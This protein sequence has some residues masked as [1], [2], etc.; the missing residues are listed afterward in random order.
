MKTKQKKRYTDTFMVRMSSIATI[1]LAI[2]VILMITLSITGLREL[3]RTMTFDKFESIAVLI[4]NSSQ[5]AIDG[6]MKA[7][8]EEQD[9]TL[10]F[11]RD[12]KYVYSTD[13]SL[14]GIESEV[15]KGDE[16]LIIHDIDGV[17]YL[18]ATFDM[19]DGT[20]LLISED[21]NHYLNLLSPYQKNLFCTGVIML[22]AFTASVAV[23]SVKISKALIKVEQAVN[24][25][26]SGKLNNEYDAKLLE[27]KDEIGDIYRN[28]KIMDDM[29]VDIV[30]KMQSTINDLKESASVIKLSVETCI[31]NTNGIASA[32]EEVAQGA[33][34]QANEC[35]N[36][37]NAT[38]EINAF[39]ENVVDESNGLKGVSANMSALKD[40]SLNSLNRLVAQNEENTASIQGIAE[41]IEQTNVSIENVVEIIQKIE[42]ISSQTNL[43]SLNASIEAARAGEAGRGFAVVAGEIKALSEQTS[44]LTK[45]IADNITTLNENSAASLSMMKQVSDNSK[46]QSELI[47]ATKD[48]FVHLES[49]ID[50][51]LDGVNKIADS[52][53]ELSTQS[54]NLV[55]VLASLSAI[56]EENAASA[57]EC[58]AGA[59]SLDVIMNDLQSKVVTLE[60]NKDTLIELASFFKLS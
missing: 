1:P 10:S 38:N 12:D 17:S 59:S 37:T 40:E 9:V 3:A 50:Q 51:S 28:T 11:L 20:A 2:A 56:S 5:E 48:N 44:A 8:A 58:S 30:S 25:V 13:M 60:Q 26:G 18:S 21:R 46:S 23:L 49:N 36:G 42:Q 43:L 31:E 7:M 34:Q 41:Q 14:Y 6:E 52:M 33:S 39:I 4:Q 35:T 22:L 47:I 15:K 54:A 16:G 19:A 32:V 57:E 24:I 45:E 55:D 53:K 27:R 29:F